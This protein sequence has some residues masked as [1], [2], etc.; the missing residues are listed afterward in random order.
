MVNGTETG[1]TL[2]VNYSNLTTN[3]VA[4]HVHGPADPGEAGGIL[5]DI[6]T[7]TQAADGSYEW[8]FVP[9][10]G[11]VGVPE[12]VAAVKTG[13][14]YINIHSAKY[15]NGE[16]R[17][18]F[19]AASGS[20]TFTPPDP[21]P[22]LPG[23]PPTDQDAARFLIQ[24]T[25]GPTTEE[26]ERVK[27]IGYDA[28]LEEQFAAPTTSMLEIVKVRI[29]EQINP[30][31]SVTG[32][33]IT[34][35]WWR[36]ALTGND[37][38]RQR[39]ALAYSE[40]F[41]VSK[42]EESIEA[43]PTGLCTYHDMLANNAF[44]NFRTLLRDVTLHPI[45]GQY[46]NMRGNRKP[47]S[48][49]FTPPNENYAR[50]VLQ[51]FSVGVVHLH[52]DGTLKLGADGL[53]L[54]T[55]E[56]NEIEA[57]SHVFTGWDLST[58][59]VDIPYWNGTAVAI[60]SSRYINPMVVTA[61]RHSNDPK[62]LLRYTGALYQLPRNNSHTVATSNA[63]LE[64]ALDNIFNH[65]NVGPFIARRLIQRM[66]CSNPSPG[67]VYRV[68]QAFNNNGSGVRGDMKAVVKA[69]LTDYEARS[70]TML[71]NLGWGKLKEPML[72]LTHIIRAFHPFSNATPPIWRLQQMDT[73]MGQTVYRSPTVFNF[74]EPDYV[75]PGAIAQAGLF[76][77]EFQISTENT[78]ILTINGFK[79]G[80]V[81]N[82][83]P[84][85]PSGAVSDVRINLAT[86]QALAS[87][88][89]ALLD[90][91][92]KV[93]MSGQ[94]PQNMRDR[95]KTYLNTISAADLPRRARG[96]VY[97]VAASPQFATQK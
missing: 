15:P 22:P 43:Q 33:R 50:E 82:N 36:M 78:N 9:V 30:P 74:F 95:I 58:V 75:Y 7:A 32:Q 44:G 14:T 35:A 41:V 31:N 65:P 48:P 45:M 53:P 84:F 5:F 37:Q 68:A 59:P 40:I 6:D 4:W 18:H 71:G 61:S 93:L 34:D 17:G 83:L 25:F 26:I 24:A 13:R 56:Q 1:A 12:I 66:V 64:Y 55:Y 2:R 38:L 70:T 92:N 29:A 87:D 27:S 10:G 85:G 76:S 73:D 67:Y 46:L 3:R 21:P 80:I 79:R 63:E 57:F 60:N 54:A 23:G 72:R 81:D 49:N 8:T 96:A 62:N 52:P 20:Q 16:I 88:P 89:D 69:V 47:V 51:L 11:G 97:L 94:M 19:Q 77:P 91:L 28:W 86:E 42:I 39:V 90:H